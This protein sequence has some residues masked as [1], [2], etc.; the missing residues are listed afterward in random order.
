MLEWLEEHRT[1]VLM[2]AISFGLGL[3][4]LAAAAVAVVRMPAGALQENHNGG[5]RAWRIARGILGWLLIAAGIAMLILPGPGLVVLL[6]G[7]TLA[8]FPGRCR[9]QHWICT[10]KHVLSSINR[11]RKRFH[12]PPL[13]RSVC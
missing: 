3:V 11:L 7:I 9:I 8:D 1:A 5:S 4:A 13:K 12:R 10:R 2:A 6:L